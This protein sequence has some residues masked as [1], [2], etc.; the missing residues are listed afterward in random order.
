VVVFRQVLEGMVERVE[1][2]LAVS[3]LDLDGIAVDSTN[4]GG[5]PLDA[6]AAELIAAYK[7]VQ[8]TNTGIDTGEVE[9]VSVVTDRYIVFLSAVSSDYY[10]LMVMS[11]EG[12]HGRARYELRRARHA[13]A[14]EL[15]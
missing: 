4:P 7:S 5:I 1:G 2:T 9:Q 6:I 15:I 14:D 8:L 11:P 10:V 12:S 13:L 3:L